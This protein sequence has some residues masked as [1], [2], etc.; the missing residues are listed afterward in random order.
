MPR[1]Q[2]ACPPTWLFGGYAGVVNDTVHGGLLGG[3]DAAA[4][5]LAHFVGA[6]D[7]AQSMKDAGFWHYDA[8]ALAAWTQDAVAVLQERWGGEEDAAAARDPFEAGAAARLAAEGAAVRAALPELQ[9]YRARCGA[10]AGLQTCCSAFAA[11]ARA[12][13][14]CLGLWLVCP[15]CCR[16]LLGSEL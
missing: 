2:A 12:G 16:V 1:L 5:A 10:G 7:K 15:R 4:P 14:G 9:A 11:L 6:P 13:C 3:W 8:D